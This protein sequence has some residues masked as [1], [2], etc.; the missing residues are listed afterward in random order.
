MSKTNKKTKNILNSNWK[1]ITTRISKGESL[2]SVAQLFGVSK[3]AL[4]ARLK[5]T[6]AKLKSSAANP[7]AKVLVMDIETSPFT[8]YSYNR[9][10]VNISDAMRRDDDIMILSFAYKWLGEDEV[11]YEENRNHCDKA[12]LQKLSKVLSEADVVIGHNMGKFDTP[13]VNTR[14]VMNNLP[15]VRPYRIIDTLKIAKRHYRFERNT[16]DWVARSLGC[17]RKLEHKNFPGMSIWIEMLHG[18]DEAWAENKDY[19][20]MDVIVTEEI[21]E[22]MKP[23]TKPHAS[24]VV[25]SG[26]TMKR[27]VTCGSTKLKPA[28][29]AY[30]NVSKFQ[31]YECED[32]HSFSRGRTNLLPKEAREN[33]LA[34][35][36]GI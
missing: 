23:F 32:C 2:S 10:Q 8:A 20:K 22:K 19:N 34:P 14:L 27:C 24:L 5:R 15:P 16:L 30:T 11:F 7:T 1:D 25:G 12:I 6:S 31:Q 35:V 29:Y 17:S 18:N 4:S 36:T 26:S 21:Y 3:Q 13:M 33:L 28:G 9:W